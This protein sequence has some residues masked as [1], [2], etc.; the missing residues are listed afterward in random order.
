MQWHTDCII[1][2]SRFQL[3]LNSRLL[4]LGS[5]FTEHIGSKLQAFRMHALINPTGILFHPVSIA[6][7][8]KASMQGKFLMPTDVFHHAGAWRHL[9]VHSSL[10]H[11]DREVY[12]QNLQQAQSDLQVAWQTGTHVMITFGT[13]WGYL[14]KQTGQLVANNHKLP[15]H[16]FDKMLY[17]IADIVDAWDALLLSPE[18]QSKQWLFTVSPVRHLKDGFTENARSKAILL[19]AIHQLATKHQHVSYF[20]AYEIM[21]DDLR[22]YR[23][24]DADMLHP[25]ATAIEYI[26]DKLCQSCMRQDVLAWFKDYQPIILAKNHRPF[27]PETEEY[28]QF[29]QRNIALIQRLHMQYPMMQLDDDLRFFN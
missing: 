22:D 18:A 16:Q 17:A 6:N 14:F 13:A 9:D 3:D 15:A 25:N 26:W 19:E 29:V 8:L 28:Q 7:T 21:L 20:P 11:S 5:C 4:L 2:E 23:F 12:M 24:Y 1:P 10:S 27:F